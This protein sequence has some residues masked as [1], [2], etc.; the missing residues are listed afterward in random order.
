[1]LEHI[2][3][4][5][6]IPLNVSFV[7]FHCLLSEFNFCH[8]IVSRDYSFDVM[9][10]F[11]L[12]ILIKWFRYLCVGGAVVRGQSNGNARQCRI[13]TVCVGCT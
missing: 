5:V 2:A 4:T 12:F 11:V 3:P 1:L 9:H 13:K 10:G 7:L 8:N 6:F